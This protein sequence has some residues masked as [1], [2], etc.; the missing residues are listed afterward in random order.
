MRIIVYIALAVLLI[1]CDHFP[2]SEYGIGKYDAVLANQICED[3]SILSNEHSLVAREHARKSTLCYFSDSELNGVVLGARVL[4]E[5][6]VVDIQ[7]FNSKKK[8]ASLRKDTEEMIF[9]KYPDV[10]INR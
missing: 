10:Q 3:L 6:I 7:G 4:D 8:I 2:K 1:S 5:Q 9:S